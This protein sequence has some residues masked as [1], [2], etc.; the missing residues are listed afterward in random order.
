MD[1][2]SALLQLPDSIEEKVPL[3]ADHSTIVKFD[4]NYSRGYTSARDRL[5]QFERDAPNVVAA[6]FGT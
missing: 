4:T 2:E 6:R 5:V 3:D 1:T